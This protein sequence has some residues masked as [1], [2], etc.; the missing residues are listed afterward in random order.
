[1]TSSTS[2]PDRIPVSVI[3]VTKCEAVNL[4]RCLAALTRFDEV[5]V[6]D[7]DSR[8]GS[9]AIAAAH[10]ARFVPFTWDGG[11][12]KKRQWCLDHLTLRHDQILFVD[13]DEVVTDALADE[14]ARLDWRHPG[15]YVPG[16]YAVRDRVLKRGIQNEK[17]CLF[18]RRAA[19]FPAVDDLGSAIGEIEGHYQ[20][21]IDGGRKAGRLKAYMLHHA[22]DDPARHAARHAVYAAWRQ[23]VAARGIALG[24]TRVSKRTLRQLFERL[25][26][27]RAA[28]WVY[29]YIVRG[30]VMEARWN[31]DIYRQ[32]CRYLGL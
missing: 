6:V 12:P 11:Y 25:P 21:V 1:M 17:L 27:K 28:F 14:I 8:D 9:E 24:E 22:L 26:C 23:D 10:G 29:F 4:P 7:S 2:I 16:R 13:A 19:R 31:R 5:V 15:Y 18:D 32:K 20:P 30:G 3:V